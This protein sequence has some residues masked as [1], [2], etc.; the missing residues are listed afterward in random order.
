MAAAHKTVLLFSEKGMTCRSCLFLCYQFTQPD[1]Q[2]IK[3]L[4]TDEIMIQKH[5]DQLDR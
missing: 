4:S 3:S 2:T 1:K 5:Q